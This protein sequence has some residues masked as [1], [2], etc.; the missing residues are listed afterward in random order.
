M[1][2]IYQG[3]SVSIFT[4]L[5]SSELWGRGG[6]TKRDA[7]TQSLSHRIALYIYRFF[8]FKG[9][10][11]HFQLFL[12]KYVSFFLLCRWDI[13][14]ENVIYLSWMPCN[15]LYV[16]C[17]NSNFPSLQ[18]ACPYMICKAQVKTG[19]TLLSSFITK[20]DMLCLPFQVGYKLQV[21]KYQGYL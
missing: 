16:F 20:I 8:K 1:S 15:H 11:T 2:L 5:P 7:L 14:I 21:L 13:P 3:R 19:S 17:S 18:Y 10:I 6:Q 12:L 4:S 9:I